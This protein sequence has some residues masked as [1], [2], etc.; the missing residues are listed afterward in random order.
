[1]FKPIVA[2]AD[3][4]GEPLAQAQ[5]LAS[6]IAHLVY[7]E[8][9]FGERLIAALE[10]ASSTKKNGNSSGSFGFADQGRERPLLTLLN[11]F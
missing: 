7:T 10:P 8:A 5:Q 4:L 2:L 6:K 1:V 3:L 11:G 9:V